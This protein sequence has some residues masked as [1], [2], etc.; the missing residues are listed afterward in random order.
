ME[1]EKSEIQSDFVAKEIENFS[2]INANNFKE[3]KKLEKEYEDQIKTFEFCQWW[4][5]CYY[6]MDSTGQWR[7]IVCRA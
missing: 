3:F 1:K 2:G 6:C 5:N 7:K 4:N